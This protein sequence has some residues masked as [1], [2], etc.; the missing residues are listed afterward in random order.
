MSMI[1]LQSLHTETIRS[2]IALCRSLLKAPTQ[3]AEE[4]VLEILLCLEL[5]RRIP[6]GACEEDEAESPGGGS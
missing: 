2:S 6:E 5:V 3:E 1:C 4:C